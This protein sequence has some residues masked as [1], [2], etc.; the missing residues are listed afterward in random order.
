MSSKLV[1]SRSESP[2]LAKSTPTLRNSGVEKCDLPS[3]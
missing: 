1:P 3:S 2:H